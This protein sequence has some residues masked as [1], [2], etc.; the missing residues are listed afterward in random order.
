LHLNERVSAANCRD[1]AKAG[2]RRLLTAEAWFR[3]WVSASEICGGQSGTGTGFRLSSSVFPCQ[4]HFTP[5]PYSL[6]YH[7][8]EGQW[9]RWGPVTQ[10]QS[11]P[12]ATIKEK[13]CYLVV[14]NFV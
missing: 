9:D 11:C 5:A 1:T 3:P 4:Y 8:G 12:I 14:M 7:L 10:R 13:C 6:M 2:S